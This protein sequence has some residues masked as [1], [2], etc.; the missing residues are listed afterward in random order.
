MVLPPE[1]EKL[2]ELLAENTHE[3]WATQRMKEGWVHGAERNDEKKHHPCLVPYADLSN[4]EREYDRIT[5]INTLK[6]LLKMGYTLQSSAAAVAA[7]E[8]DTEQPSAVVPAGGKPGAVRYGR[9]TIVA[10]TGNAELAPTEPVL[11]L[12]VEK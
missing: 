12:A 11:E 5:S 7:D 2:T 6:L 4:G 9:E 3:E 1:L 8:E 10:K